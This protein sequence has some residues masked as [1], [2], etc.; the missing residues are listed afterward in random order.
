[1]RRLGT[2]STRNIVTA[3]AGFLALLLM[4]YFCALPGDLPA[5]SNN[6]SGL[7]GTY[8][9]N[10][11][12]PLGVEYSGTVVIVQANTG[13]DIEWIV[14]GGIHRGTGTRVGDRFDVQ[15]QAVASSGGIGEGSA[16]YDILDDGRLVGVR[17]V[18]GFDTAGTEE[19]FPTP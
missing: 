4:L 15:W 10:G 16:Q 5:D 3:V 14:T 9:V 13:F 1:M 18:D 6:S 11:V 12:D 17:T 19:I 7:A 8:S 2:V